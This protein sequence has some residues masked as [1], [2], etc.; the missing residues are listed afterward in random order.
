MWLVATVLVNKETVIM[1]MLRTVANRWWQVRKADLLSK[2]MGMSPGMMIP[3]G[4][5]EVKLVDLP[6]CLSS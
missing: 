2:D 1:P 3:T 4:K 5:L 6:V